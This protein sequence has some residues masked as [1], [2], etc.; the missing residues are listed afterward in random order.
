[1]SVLLTQTLQR[2]ILDEV[3]AAVEYT[4]AERQQFRQQ[5]YQQHHD[6]AQMRLLH[7]GVTSEQFEQWLDRELKI[8]IFQWRQWGKTLGSYFLQRKRELDRVTYSIIYL[9][10]ADLAQELYFRIAEGE[11]TFAELAYLHSQGAEAQTGGRVEPT[12]LGKLPPRLAQMF[13]GARPGQLWSPTKLEGWMVI[14]RLD[15]HFPVQLDGA[16]QQTLL[17]EQLENWLQAEV[18]RRFS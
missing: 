9:D 12:E 1:M 10:D 8:R 11:Q 14:V 18:K 15:G 3:I 7:E 6:P 16:M 5:F 4:E 13:Y 2:L 17:N